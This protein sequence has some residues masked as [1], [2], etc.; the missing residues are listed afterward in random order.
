MRCKTIITLQQTSSSIETND[1]F[2][3]WQAQ[4]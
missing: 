4:W 1:V 3:S 2:V